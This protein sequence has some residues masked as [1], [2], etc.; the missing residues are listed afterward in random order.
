MQSLSSTPNSAE[1]TRASVLLPGG[2]WKE[3]SW[4]CLLQR[5]DAHIHKGGEH[6]EQFHLRG[7]T[8]MVKRPSWAKSQFWGLLRPLGVR[9]DVGSSKWHQ[10]SWS[11]RAIARDCFTPESC[12]G[13]ACKSNVLPIPTFS[14]FSLAIFSSFRVVTFECSRLGNDRI[15]KGHS[16]ERVK[17]WKPYRVLR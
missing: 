12:F 2:S 5:N 6:R 1:E 15:F 4:L 11:A 17:D 8:I 3:S 7:L 13:F 16:T 9:A 10:D 14:R